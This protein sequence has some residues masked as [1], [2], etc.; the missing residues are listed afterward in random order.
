MSR[1]SP[2]MEWKN[3]HYDGRVFLLIRER[4]WRDVQYDGLFS[5]LFMIGG[6]DRCNSPWV[7]KDS[8]EMFNELGG[9]NRGPDNNLSRT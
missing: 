4:R 3:H 2:R 5:S 1:S 9:G 7:F 6:R 8:Y